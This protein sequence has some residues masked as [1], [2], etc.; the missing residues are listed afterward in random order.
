MQAGE[1]SWPKAGV[2]EKILSCLSVSV[3]SQ[4]DEFKICV[5]YPI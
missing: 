2:A 5:T 3:Q 4:T 1:F